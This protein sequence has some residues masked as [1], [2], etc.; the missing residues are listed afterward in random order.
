MSTRIF[1]VTLLS[2]ALLS[3]CSSPSD[4]GPARAHSRIVSKDVGPLL[5]EAKALGDAGNYQGAL[6]KL[7]E[8]EAVKSRPDDTTV[9]NE[10][11]YY[12]EFK[13]ASSAP[14]QP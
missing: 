3:S 10:F 14:S 1:F 11:R 13:M 8:A 5:I 7:N 6:A 4:T 2:A 9:I 12:V